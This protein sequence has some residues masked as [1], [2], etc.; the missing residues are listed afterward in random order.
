MAS[1]GILKFLLAPSTLGMSKKWHT[2]VLMTYTIY[3][4]V[5]FTDVFWA[6]VI[7]KRRLETGIPGNASRTHEDLDLFSRMQHP[8][9]ST[10]KV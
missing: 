1:F 10:A 7:W 5:A 9:S 4:E 6:S 8:V 2:L 3:G